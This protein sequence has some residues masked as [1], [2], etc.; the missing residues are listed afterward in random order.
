VPA[1]QWWFD[2]NVR[3]ME[4]TNVAEMH[5]TSGH[6]QVRG[7]I[8]LMKWMR[9][10]NYMSYSNWCRTKK[11]HRTSLGGKARELAS[12]MVGLTSDARPWRA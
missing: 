2:L 1:K 7:V 5:P 4:S 10:G 9:D 11:L 6:K 3:P 12:G 8:R